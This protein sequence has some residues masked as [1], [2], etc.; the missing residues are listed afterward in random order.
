MNNRIV[1]QVVNIVTLAITLTV[2]TLANTLPLNGQTTGE[3]S[4]KFPVRFVP[5]GYVFSIWGV[6]YL[7][8]I[9]FVLY[10]ALPAQRGN[11]RIQRLWP[12]FAVSNL[13]NAIWLFCWHYEQFV[14]TEVFMLMLLAC[15]VRIYTHLDRDRRESRGA[16]RWLVDLPFSIY[17]GWI[18]VATIANTQDL[19]YSLGWNG[20]GISGEAW[21]VALLVVATAIGAAIAVPRGDWAYASV[22]LWAFIG[23]GVKQSDSSLV[24]TASWVA[25][26]VVG[27][28]IVVS[29]LRGGPRNR[30]LQPLTSART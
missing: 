25:A 4:D 17:L 28:I 30:Q 11:E 18:T 20:S 2:N 22:L 13:V 14:L 6:I 7:G 5:A 27:V 3:V 21:A 8:L 19:L 29:L 10:Q 12:W 9:G 23:I 26:V 24:T 1:H 15:L 16:Q